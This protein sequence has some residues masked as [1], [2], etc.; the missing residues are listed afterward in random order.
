[1]KWEDDIRG[2]FVMMVQTLAMLILFILVNITLGLF[3][4]LAFFEESIGIKNILFY[5]FFIV[6]LIYVAR[7]IY[8]K[9]NARIF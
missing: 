2:F 3:F 7:Y 5:L 1:M 8:K 9:W 4:K 6:S